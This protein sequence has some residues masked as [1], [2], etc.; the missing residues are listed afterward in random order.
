LEPLIEDYDHW[1]AFAL[2]LIVGVHMLRLAPA[3]AGADPASDPSRGIT[4]I[5]LSTAVSVDALAVGLS[6]GL[7][8]VEIWTAA[9][10]IGVVTGTISLLGIVLGTRIHIRFGRVAETV[11]GVTLILIGT[12][13]LLSHLGMI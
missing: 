12:R 2:L 9:F 7:L 4:L 8:R 5:A 6:L 3:V 13:V 1:L 10:L 11:G